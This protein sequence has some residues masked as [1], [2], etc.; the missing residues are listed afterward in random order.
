MRFIPMLII[1]KS[2]PLLSNMDADLV[3]AGG[4]PSLKHS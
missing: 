1:L 4:S 2:K 3:K